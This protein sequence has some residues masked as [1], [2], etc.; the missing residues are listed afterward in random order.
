M[1]INRNKLAYGLFFVLVAVFILIALKGLMAPQPGDEN[2]YYYMGRLISEGKIPYK[3]FFFAHPPLHIYLIA[4]IYKIFGFNIIF[5]KSIPLI[6]TLISAFFIFKI[7]NE[8]FGNAE[9]ILSSLLFLFSYSTMFNSVFSFGIDVAT[10]FLVVGVYFLWNKNNYIL[11]GIFFGLAG[12]TRLLTLMPIFVILVAVLFSNKKNFLKLSLGF[13]ILFLF[14]NGIFA[15]FFGDNY[16]T[17]VYK[18]HLLKSFGSKENYKEYADILK[19]NWL[20]FSTFSLF[21][22]VKEKKPISISAIVSFTYLLFLIT[23]KKIFGFYFIVIFPFLAIIGSY[24]IL[25]LFKA[26]KKFNLS[27]NVNILISIVFFSIFAWNLTAD[28][29]FLEKIGF[30]GFERGKDLVDFINSVSNKDTQLFG[31]D[32]VVP[33]MALLTNKKITLDFVDTN[34]QVFLSGV[35]DLKGVLADLKGKDVLFIIRSAQ[36]ISYFS[37]VKEFLNSKCK[38]LSKFHDKIEGSY[39]V[40]RCR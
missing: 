36:G 19:L 38:F 37:E 35:R 23:L 9:A 40:Y 21:I 1:A 39:L 8:K 30:K 29:L 31:D 4:L 27:K 15:F 20:L 14:A 33:L 22:F 12:I 5:L 11:S 7:A 34:N 17:P 16:L 3:D 28:T 10:M 13:L 24:S 26:F 32:S 18:F 25:S 6:S 2:T